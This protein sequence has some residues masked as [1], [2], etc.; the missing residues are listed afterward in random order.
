MN[1]GINPRHPV[2]GN[3]Q[4][5]IDHRTRM[6]LQNRPPVA[7]NIPAQQHFQATQ[8][9]QTRMPAARN[10]ISEPYDILQQ[11]R[12]TGKLK[13]FQ[14]RSSKIFQ[15]QFLN[16]LFRQKFLIFKGIKVMILQYSFLYTF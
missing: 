1:S 15:N 5:P 10:A 6:L 14:K 2:A 16:Q 3:I 13:N 4:N 11:Q 7:T 9:L 8:S 12:F